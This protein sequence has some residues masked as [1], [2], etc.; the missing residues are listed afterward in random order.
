MQLISWRTLSS[1]GG[2]GGIINWAPIYAMAF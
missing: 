2:A 1:W